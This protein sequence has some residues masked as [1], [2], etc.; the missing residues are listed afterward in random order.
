MTEAIPLAYQYESFDELEKHL[1]D[2]KPT[3]VKSLYALVGR[4]YEVFWYWRGRYRVVLGSRASKKSMTTAIWYIV[5]MM[6]MSKA[7]LLVVRMIADTNRDSTYAT[8]IKVIHILGVQDLW[9]WSKAPLEITYK[10]T[11]QKI[12]FR[13]LDDPHKLSSIDVPNGVLCWAWF[14][15]AYQIPSEEMFDKVDQSIRGRMP[16]GYFPQITLTFN[17][18]NQNHW[19]KRRFFDNPDS[20]TLAMRTNYTINEFLSDFDRSFFERM[21]VQNPRMYEVAG[22]GNWG[23]SEGLIYTDWEVREFDLDEILKR[24]SVRL[25][26]GLDFGY[27]NDPTALVASA[28]DLDRHEIYVYDEWLALRQ[29][30]RMIA[31]AIRDRGWENEIIVCDSASPQNIGELTSELGI[32]AVASIKGKDSVENGIQMLQ[33]YHQVILPKCV[34]YRRE[35][36]SYSYAQDRLGNTMNVPIDDFNHCLVAGTLVKTMHGDVPIERVSVGDM[37]LTHRGYR[38]VTASGITRPEPAEIWRLTCEDGTVIE[39]TDDHPFPTNRGVVR[40]RDCKGAFL[41]KRGAVTP[42]RVS[43]CTAVHNLLDSPSDWRLNRR[44][45]DRTRDEWFHDIMLGRD[46]ENGLVGVVSVE[47]TGRREYVYDLT[48]DEA[49]DFYANGLLTQNCMDAERYA[50]GYLILRDGG[51]FYGEARGWVDMSDPEQAKDAEERM[52][53]TRYVFST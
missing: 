31:D 34:N 28:V 26:W 6:E 18:W 38:R 11:G 37:V 40:L 19:L 30:N 9:A 44:Y 29:T 27:S 49:H 41:I 13:G 8:L 46:A 48:V 16:P 1:G 33:G 3:N 14:E 10:P 5:H 52:R 45:R 17:P 7:N 50:L 25:I 24:Q 47:R 32:N 43:G 15:E 4:G 23:V 12:I 39:G 21:R 36:E 35:I 22:L 20:E 53:H 51:G 42:E 2:I